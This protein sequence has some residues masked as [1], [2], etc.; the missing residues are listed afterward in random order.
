MVIH[1]GKVFSM[2]SVAMVCCAGSLLAD[3]PGQPKARHANLIENGSFEQRAQGA[4]NPFIESLAPGSGV[5]LGWKIIAPETH[6]PAEKGDRGQ[7]LLNVD[8]IGPRRW[9]ASH[10]DHCLDLDGGIQ[11][12]VP[13]SPGKRYTLRFDL[14]GNP[15]C[16]PRVQRLRILID[17]KAHDFEFDST[18]KSKTDLGWVTKE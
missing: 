7:T 8:W 14:A 1:L 17:Q 5:L 12:V 6:L 2:A 15:E 10:C 3:M 16:G 18:G 4:P 9:R 13:T 11:Q